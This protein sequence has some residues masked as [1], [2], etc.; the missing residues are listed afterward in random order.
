MRP[1]DES[2]ESSDD[3]DTEIER[4]ETLRQNLGDAFDEFYS[5]SETEAR[6]EARADILGEFYGGRPLDANDLPE[7]VVLAH[8]RGLAWLFY[9][10]I[11]EGDQV[12]VDGE[13]DPDIEY[14]D[15]EE[16]LSSVAPSVDQ[17]GTEPVSSDTDIPREDVSD[18][19]ALPRR[20]AVDEWLFGE[21]DESQEDTSG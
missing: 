16:V 11:L 4:L 19:V 1:P 2:P 3:L 10:D 7:I 5:E 8:A 13:W 20:S 14:D 6:R 12:H 17:E 18:K 15:P 21:G 9:P